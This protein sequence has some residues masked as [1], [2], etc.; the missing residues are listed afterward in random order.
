MFFIHQ[1]KSRYNLNIAFQLNYRCLFHE[2][3]KYNRKSTSR[4]CVRNK[5]NSNKNNTKTGH[6]GSYLK[7]THQKYYTMNKNVII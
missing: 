4:N 1:M 5:N 2:N 7:I 6:I 3:Q